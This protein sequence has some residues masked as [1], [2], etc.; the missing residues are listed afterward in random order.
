MSL[1]PVINGTNEA[2]YNET[3]YRFKPNSG[4]EF[5]G[6][7]E[8]IDSAIVALTNA[9]VAFGYQ[10]DYKKSKNA[11]SSVAFSSSF[12]STRGGSPTNPNID[13][14]DVWELVRNTVQKE[15]LESD[16]PLIAAVTNIGD[17]GNLGNMDRLKQLFANPQLWDSTA[18]DIFA[19]TGD[20]AP[21]QAASV[22]LFNLF[23]SGVKT[24]EVK[25]PILRLTR[26]TNPLYDAPFNVD[27]IDTLLTTA[28]MQ[29][30]SGVPSNFAI[31]LISLASQLV[32]KA[33]PG[34]VPSNLVQVRSDGLTLQF[35]WLKDLTSA[36]IRGSERVSYIE[37]YKFGLYDVGLYGY[38][39]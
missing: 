35:A 31:P 2:V 21:S 15:L 30:D 5:G 24:V 16:H 13:Y 19:N 33:F 28:S 3:F 27:N 20:G 18:A 1:L 6:T 14:K 11:I 25:Q 9:L 8:G 34:G 32:L 29:S 12:S 37:E 10:V 7:Y 36:T 26:T 17:A 23:R 38:A 4:G 39:S 22:Y